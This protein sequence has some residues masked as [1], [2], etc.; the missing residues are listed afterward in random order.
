M[1]SFGVEKVYEYLAKNSDCFVIIGGIAVYLV[2]KDKGMPFRETHDFDIV[3]LTDGTNEDFNSAIIKLINDGGYEKAFSNGKDVYY[4]FIN[5]KNKEFPKTIE[6]FARNNGKLSQ[7]LEKIKIVDDEDE[8]LSA[9]TL[10]GEIFNFINSRKIISEEGLPVVDT[11]GLIA[12]KIYAYFKNLELYQN[13][14]VIGKDKYQ[15]HL[16]DVIRLLLSITP[17][18]DFINLDGEIEKY[19]LMFVD[20]LRHSKQ[21]HDSIAHGLISLEETVNLYQTTF[22][23]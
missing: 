9:I 2:L 21:V 1:N 4:R 7:R 15:K 17:E 18:E 10:D 13:G 14:F 12:L 20:V 19:C 16:K 8:Q 5:P 6:L 22:C 23:K 11:L 3:V